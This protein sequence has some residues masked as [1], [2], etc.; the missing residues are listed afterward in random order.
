MEKSVN[1]IPLLIGLVAGQRSM[2]PLAAVAMAARSG[3]LAR[4]NGAPGV[5]G[6]TSVVIG[7]SILAVGELLGD[8]MRSAPDRTVPPG[9]AARLVSGALAGAALAPHARRLQAGGALGAVGAVV[10]GY[11]GLAVRKRALRRFGQT[12][13]G[14]V[15]DALTLG[16][17][18]LIMRADRRQSSRCSAVA[19]QKARPTG[20]Q[21]AQYSD[22]QE[23][24]T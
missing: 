8:K 15:E 19:L 10:G 14:L 18:T 17:T 5:M 13:S 16:A 24:P 7:A 11:V 2:T 20:R 21:P 1:W 4:D 9:L 12:K 3:G 6:R 22:K 23:K